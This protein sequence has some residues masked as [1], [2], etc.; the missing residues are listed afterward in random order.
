MFKNRL[1]NILLII[2]LTLTIIGLAA[3][4][5]YSQVLNGEEENG[6]PPIDKI[7]DLTVETDEIT[8]N[9]FSNNIIR[10]NFVIQV[11]N[12]KA[13]KELDKRSFQLRNIIIEELND[14]SEADFKGSHKIDELEEQIGIRINEILQE[15]Y[16]VEVYINQLII[17]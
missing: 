9:L 6:E 17:K 3:F 7:L 14:R 5:L 11:D 16:V 12:R 4:I 10:A 1:A 2:L 8:T 13:K 15:G